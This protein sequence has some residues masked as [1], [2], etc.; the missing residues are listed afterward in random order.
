MKAIPVETEFF[1]F[2]FPRLDTVVRVEV[3]GDD[4]TIRVSRDSFSERR[5]DYFVREL[6]A[7]GFIPESSVWGVAGGSPRWVVDYTWL[8]ID[9]AVR[10]C[11][12]RL[13][14]RLFSGSV[15]LLAL[16]FGLLFSG[17]LGNVRYQ[18]SERAPI[19]ASQGPPLAGK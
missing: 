11:A 16:L 6:A 17:H 3:R 19:A 1:D 10:A 18:S 7:E 8:E 14:F 9:P 5:K 4:V 2:G 12:N 15:L 13:V